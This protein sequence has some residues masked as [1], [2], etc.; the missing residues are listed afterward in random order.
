MANIAL[1]GKDVAFS[2]TPSLAVEAGGIVTDF[3]DMVSAINAAVLSDDDKRIFLLTDAVVFF[4][5]EI[6]QG[7]DISRSF[8]DQDQRTF[9]WQS[10]EFLSPNHTPLTRAS[11]Y[12]HDCVHLDQFDRTGRQARDETEEVAREIE[13]VVRQIE[14][15]RALGVGQYFIDY[16]ISYEADPIQIASRVDSGVVLAANRTCRKAGMPEVFET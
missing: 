2:V 16:L 9:N 12:F 7:E 1:L 8:M 5:R 11:Y 10:D 13:A 4:D 14:V 3:Q 6:W 15:S